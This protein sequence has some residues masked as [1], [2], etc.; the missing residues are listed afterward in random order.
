MKRSIF[1]DVRTID[2]ILELTKQTPATA[3]AKFSSSHP[4]L[5]IREFQYK[6]LNLIIFTNKKLYHFKMVESPLCAFCKEEEESAL[7]HLL[8]LLS[9][10]RSFTLACR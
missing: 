7:E 1:D 5:S 4:D 6:L 9:L 10:E 3:K 8:F 2:G